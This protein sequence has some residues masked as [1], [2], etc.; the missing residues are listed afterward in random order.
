MGR[1][2]DV[3]NNALETKVPFITENTFTF[4]SL[5]IK[6]IKIKTNKFNSKRIAS[7]LLRIKLDFL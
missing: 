5:R 3:S 7:T 1:E 2:A 6:G 4:F